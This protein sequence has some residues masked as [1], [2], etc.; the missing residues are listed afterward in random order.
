MYHRTLEGDHSRKEQFSVATM[1]AANGIGTEEEGF[2]TE[3]TNDPTLSALASETGHAP[4]STCPTSSGGSTCSDP[5]G[6]FLSY[7]KSGDLFEMVAWVVFMAIL[8]GLPRLTASVWRRDIP[9]QESAA[10][11]VL[12]EL[13]FDNELVDETVN[14]QLL[15][16]LGVLVPLSLQVILCLTCG[17]SWHDVHRGIC[18]FSTAIGL[19]TF[20]VEFAKHYVGYLR[21]NFY[22]K[23]GFDYGTMQCDPDTDTDSFTGRKSFMSGHSSMSFAGL[24]LLS[25]YMQRLFG[26]GS[27]TKRAVV[28][29]GTGADS[30]GNEGGTVFLRYISLSPSVQRRKR[31][32]SVLC[33]IPMFLAV[34]IAASRVRDNYHHP[35]DVVGGSIVGASAAIW[36]MEIWFDSSPIEIMSAA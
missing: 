26:V 23:C 27:G 9:Y 35:A 20:I 15:I 24:T 34:F 31:V 30:T 11:D 8:S 29:G 22:A 7:A 21:P 25:L 19:S 14:N 4:Q 33:L 1:P 3:A 32:L 18:A 10:G 5:V 16:I 6:R 36:T 13:M 17:D 28:I 2:A 12:L